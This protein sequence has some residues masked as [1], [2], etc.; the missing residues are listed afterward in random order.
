MSLVPE[1]MVEKA[2]DTRFGSIGLLAQGGSVILYMC[3]FGLAM[4]HFIAYPYQGVPRTLIKI[5]TL[6][7]LSSSMPGL[8]GLF[9]DQNRARAAW[10]VFL[11]LPLLLL[12][13]ILDGNW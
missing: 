7:L 5:A 8:I 2:Q 9:F 11:V 12:M 10:V 4:G 1:R 3:C 13:A 6:L